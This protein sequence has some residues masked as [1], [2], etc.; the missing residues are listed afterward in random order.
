MAIIFHK[1]HCFK[2]DVW[3]FSN[4]DIVNFNCELLQTDWSEIFKNCFD[5]DIIYEKWYR[6]FR[7]IVEKYI[8]FK[9]VT[10]RLKDKPWMCGQVRLAI[11]K[12]N[13]FLK[14]HNRNPTLTTWERYRAQRNRT[15]SLIRKA[16]NSYY[17]KLNADLCDQ[18][19]SSK[20]WWGL[21]KQVY[22]NNNKPLFSSALMENGVLITDSLDKAH[23]FNEFFATQT[24]LDGADNIPPDIESFQSSIYISNIVASTQ[25]VYS[26]MKYV[27]ITKACGHDGVGNK[28]I[29]LCCEG[30][31]EFFTNFINLSFAL[32]KFPFQWKLANVIP[33]FKKDDCQ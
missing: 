28:I 1:S 5:V 2:R 33:L 8:P 32:G 13:R 7:R 6:I 23:I 26:L 27:D 21:V 16:K 31:C 30:F 15:T 9:T 17:E 22:D 11:R 12:R 3:D 29:Q 24:N 19:I 18:S 20:K 10:I 14:L 25:E 4:V